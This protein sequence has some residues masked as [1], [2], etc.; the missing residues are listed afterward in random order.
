MVPTTASSPAA[1][2]IEVSGL[3]KDYGAG[4]GIF[5]LSFDVAEGEVF[6]FLGSNGAGKTVT[7]RHLMG[8]IRPQAGSARIF[9]MDCFTQRAAIQGQLGYLPGE[10]AIYDNMRAGDY[11]KLI[12]S[13][14]GQGSTK[15]RD[16]LIERFELDPRMKVRKMSKGNKQKVDHRIRSGRTLLKCY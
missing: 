3:T 1:A 7:M 11:L 6:G 15:R 14:R 9:G 13:M 2:L 8:F 5:D 4:R 10:I 12:A 16:E